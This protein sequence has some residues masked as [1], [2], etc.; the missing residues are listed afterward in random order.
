[1][2]VVK[3]S[4]NGIIQAEIS[5]FNA[6]FELYKDKTIYGADVLSIINRA[7]ENNKVQK[8]EKDAEGNYIENNTTSVKVEIT[9]LSTDK[10][11]NIKEVTYPMERLQKVGLDG[12]IQ[13][14]SLTK[15]KCT[16]VEYN[17]QRR[18]SKIKVKQ[19][20]I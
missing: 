3:I 9:L 13:N 2:I 19:L 7:I 6:K 17:K 5:Q 8:V 12:F 11:N 1:M 18:V 16:E 15:F 20:E 14:F 10:D 4:D